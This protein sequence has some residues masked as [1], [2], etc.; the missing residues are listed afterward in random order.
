MADGQ[1]ALKW[2]NALQLFQFDSYHIDNG[3][4]A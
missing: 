4:V 3:R 2:I 1:D